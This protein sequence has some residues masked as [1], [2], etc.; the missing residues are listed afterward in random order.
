[1]SERSLF[2]KYTE[3]AYFCPLVTAIVCSA[4]PNEVP[5]KTSSSAVNSPFGEII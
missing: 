1:V 4:L 2:F 5:S 3:N